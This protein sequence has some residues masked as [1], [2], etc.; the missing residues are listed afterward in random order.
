MNL[1]YHCNHCRKTVRP[2]EGTARF[3]SYCAAYLDSERQYCRKCKSESTP[4]LRGMDTCLSC[5]ESDLAFGVGHALLDINEALKSL[6]AVGLLVGFILWEQR[7]PG[8]ASTIGCIAKKA[9]NKLHAPPA[10]FELGVLMMQV[11]AVL[12]LLTLLGPLLL[13]LV[14]KERVAATPSGMLSALIVEQFGLNLRVNLQAARRFRLSPRRFLR[15]GWK[16][17]KN[18]GEAAW[19]SLKQSWEEASR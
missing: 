9:L 4:N 1:I 14:T 6:W 11:G 19:A 13:Q 8:W 3:C 17:T 2:L 10:S 5:G 12:F 18:R 15:A 7:H 16:R